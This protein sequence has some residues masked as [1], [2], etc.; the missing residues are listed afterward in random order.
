[1]RLFDTGIEPKKKFV[2]NTMRTLATSTH[3]IGERQTEDYYATDPIAIDCLVNQEYIHLSDNVWEP[4][5]GE[6]YLSKRLIE[7][8]YNVK[9]SDLVDYGFGEVFNFLYCTKQFDGD[10][11][12]NPPYKHALEMCQHALD[13]VTNGRLVCMFL[14]LQFLEGKERKKWFEKNPPKY[15]MVC[16]SRINCA[17]DG[18]FDIYGSSAVCYAWFV[19]QKGYIGDTIVKWIN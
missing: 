13:L 9:S 15:V 7:Y 1:M 8:N 18:R 12:T 3:A 11:I 19:W 2:S 4:C 5:C 17:K 16:S 6:G 10:I 14:K